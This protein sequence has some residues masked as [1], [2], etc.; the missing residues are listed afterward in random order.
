MNVVHEDVEKLV[1]KELAAATERFGL[2]HSWHEKAAVVG[3][4]LEESCEEM[5]N[6]VDS[7]KFAWKQTRGNETDYIKEQAYKGVYD[8]AVRL[9]I[10]AIQVA[11]MAKKPVVTQEA[12]ARRPTATKHTAM[13][14]SNGYIAY[15][16]GECGKHVGR[17][18]SFCRACGAYFGE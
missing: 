9:A 1:E 18:D 4:E 17:D 8:A 13:S 3:E 14:G 2:H 16:C 6:L 7:M 5:E 15:T 10:E 11:A 12:D